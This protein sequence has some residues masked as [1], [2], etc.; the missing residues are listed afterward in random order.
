MKDFNKFIE[1]AASKRCPL[2][3]YYCYTDKKCKQIPKGYKMVGPAGYLRKENGH[4]VDDNSDSEMAMAMVTAM[5]EMVMV[6][7]T[8][9]EMV[10]VV[11]EDNNGNSI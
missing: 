9:A 3:Q 10:A 1:E 8:V 2:G 11:M 4:S 6:E 5:V 7:A